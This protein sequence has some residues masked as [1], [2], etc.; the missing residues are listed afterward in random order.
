MGVKSASGG[1]TALYIRP[2][3]AREADAEARA[4]KRMASR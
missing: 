3:R 4:R 2:I 1:A